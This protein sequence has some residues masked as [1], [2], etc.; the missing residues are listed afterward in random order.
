MLFRPA[1]NC[2]EKESKIV[3]P[4]TNDTSK[5]ETQAPTA[6]R[7]ASKVFR[8]VL[9]VCLKRLLLLLQAVA[10]HCSIPVLLQEELKSLLCLLIMV[11][12]GRRASMN[13]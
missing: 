4:A 7:S 6:E 3:M 1:S 12:A 9:D 5:H 10:A 2:C 8:L 11:Q 13:T